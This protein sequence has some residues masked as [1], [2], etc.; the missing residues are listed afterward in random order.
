MEIVFFFFRF[1]NQET[2]PR[3]PTLPVS[4]LVNGGVRCRLTRSRIIFNSKIMEKNQNFSCTEAVSTLL[5]VSRTFNR[6]CQ[7]LFFRKGVVVN[8]IQFMLIVVI[9]IGQQSCNNSDMGAVTFSDSK[10]IQPVIP[11]TNTD[12]KYTC[13]GECDENEHPWPEADDNCAWMLFDS[14]AKTFECPCEDCFMVITNSYGQFTSASH[15][16]TDANIEETYY[17]AFIT[18]LTDTF[19]TAD[20]AIASISLFYQDEYEFLA[21]EYYAPVSNQLC[22]VLYVDNPNIAGSPPDIEIDCSGGCSS[23][24]E[25]CRERY[26]L[27]T[28]DAECTCEGSCKMKVKNIN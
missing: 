18:Y 6:N 28:G 17:D 8:T 3:K 21:I 26:I 19:Q 9:G 16:F 11:R 23:P 7:R 14:D 10:N 15:T 4:A 27:S 1:I 25:T 20:V 5:L 22:T 24:S 2:R 13:G 12:R